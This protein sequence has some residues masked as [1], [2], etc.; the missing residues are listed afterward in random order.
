[1]HADYEEEAVDSILTYTLWNVL[2]SF[3][4]H[5]LLNFYEY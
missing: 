1:M 2:L 3:L 4:V 5:L